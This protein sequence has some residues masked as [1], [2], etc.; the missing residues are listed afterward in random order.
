MRP[1]A[2]TIAGSDPSGGAGIQADLKTFHQ[3]GVYGMSVVTL[4]TVQNTTEVRRC[5]TLAPSLIR[6]QLDAVLG[7]IMP[8]VIKIG[9]LGT[10]PNI[11][12]V[13]DGLATQSPPLVVDPVAL[14]SQGTRLLDQCGLT[15]LRKR[16]FP[17]ISL[18]TPNLDEASLLTG[19][20]VVDRSTMERAA[21]AIAEQGPRCVLVKGGYLTDSATDILLADG[22][23][24][25]FPADLIDTRHT[26]GTGCVLASA[27]AALIAKGHDIPTAVSKA[28]QFVTTA[29]QTA[30]K[31]GHGN[32]P[33]NLHVPL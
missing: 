21:I 29:I 4:I 6:D 32:G 15:T 26:H 28:K 17:I 31:L 2:L 7:D 5:E 12:A 27:S 18:L 19:F 24:H 22:V 30:P 20:D 3:F 14:S 11:D 23:I 33:L 13:A 25:E 1:T 8:T 10:G 9:A 16:L